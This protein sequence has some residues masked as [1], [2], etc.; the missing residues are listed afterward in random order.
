MFENISEKIKSASII[1]AT[2]GMIVSFTLAVCLF[3]SNILL[4]LITGVIGSLFSWLGALVLYGFGHLIE[5]S[6]KILKLQQE[7]AEQQFTK[8]DPD[9]N[10]Q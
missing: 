4:A 10:N 7:K 1:L 9:F 2:A 6:D 5:N 3:F 8:T